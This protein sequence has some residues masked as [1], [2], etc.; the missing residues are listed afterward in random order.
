[1]E[2]ILIADDHE[3]VRR[4]IKSIID[5]FPQK[6]NYIEATTCA[7]VGQIL[8]NQHIH[9]AI[10]DMF[11]ADGMFFSEINQ[12][13]GKYGRANIL[14][15]SMSAEKVY[16]KRLMQKGAKGFISKQSSIEELENAI[17]CLLK[18]EIYLSG[19]LK[20]NIF[21]TN[22]P[23]VLANLID[24]LSDRELEVIEY[25][26]TGMGTKEIAKKMNLDIT[27]ISTYR[28]RAFEKLD[29]SNIIELKDKFMLHKMQG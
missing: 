8:T 20:A 13:A 17:Q 5:S 15:Y 9:Y 4:G 26:S 6:Y 24:L 23:D 22:K 12:I 19:S 21:G 27:T 11:L 14:V 2:T 16:A 29:V 18:G 1:M 3:I 28:R 7:E 25:I 10:L